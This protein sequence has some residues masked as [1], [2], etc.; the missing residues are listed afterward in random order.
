ML[1]RCVYV[2]VNPQSVNETK[3]NPDICIQGVVG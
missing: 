2:T 1:L 3:G